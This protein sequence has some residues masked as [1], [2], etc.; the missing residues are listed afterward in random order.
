MDM[1]IPNWTEPCRSVDAGLIW[2]TVSFGIETFVV[3]LW[4]TLFLQ[5]VLFSIHLW[6][7]WMPF[8]VTCPSYCWAEGCYTLDTSLV[9][10]SLFK[11]VQVNLSPILLRQNAVSVECHLSPS[12][13]SHDFCK[14]GS[15]WKS[16]RLGI[17]LKIQTNSRIVWCK[18]PLMLSAIT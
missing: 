14:M 16:T 15:I 12:L 18:S 11:A 10:H 2:N 4:V 8:G 6:F 1:K 7:L 9:C 13:F 17:L 5:Y 3:L